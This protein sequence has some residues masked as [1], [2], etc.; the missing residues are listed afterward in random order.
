MSC[1]KLLGAQKQLAAQWAR[2]GAGS[3]GVRKAPNVLVMSYEHLR[4]DVDW[5]AQHH[6]LYCVLDEG[7]VIKSNK[8]RV[9][10][11]CKRVVASHRS[12]IT[13]ETER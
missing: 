3:P 2:K 13:P 6:W 10:Q 11:A 1:N 7:H 4:A 8:T 9:T 5:V 12:V